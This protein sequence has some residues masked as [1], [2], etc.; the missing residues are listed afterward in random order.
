MHSGVIESN[1]WHEMG[2]DSLNNFKLKRNLLRLTHLITALYS[3]NDNYKYA[4]ANENKKQFVKIA[5]K[6]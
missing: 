4:I 2:Y 5:K 6:S 1:R 3:S